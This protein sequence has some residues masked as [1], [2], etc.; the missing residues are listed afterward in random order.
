MK[1]PAPKNYDLAFLGFAK[2][3]AKGKS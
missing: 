3:W 1:K 2:K